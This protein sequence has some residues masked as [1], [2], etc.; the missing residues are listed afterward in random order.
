MRA[1]SS[2]GEFFVCGQLI[3]L[4]KPGGVR[5]VAVG[6]VLRRLVGK[7]LMGLDLVRSCVRGLAPGNVGSESAMGVNRWAWDCS[8]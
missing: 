3:P 7:T 8:T 6:E 1:P 4:K 2:A 5:P